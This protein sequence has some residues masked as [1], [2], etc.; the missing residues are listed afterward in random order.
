[1]WKKKQLDVKLNINLSSLSHCRVK[2]RTLLFM[3]IWNKP[4][5]N[6]I[7]KLW[8]RSLLLYFIGILTYREL[9]DKVLNSC[10]TKRTVAIKSNWY[11]LY[12]NLLRSA[13]HRHDSKRQTITKPNL[14]IKSNICYVKP[15]DKT[16]RKCLCP[17][18]YRSCLAH[19]CRPTYC[20][21]VLFLW[22]D[23]K[24]TGWF[25]LGEYQP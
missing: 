15:F 25:R 6:G 19:G 16:V 13:Q 18:T 23:F 11:S 3:M 21:K 24:T 9:T 2:L 17:L 1:M 20:C 7:L 8:D 12:S 5:W 10:S 4:K 22:Q 14:K